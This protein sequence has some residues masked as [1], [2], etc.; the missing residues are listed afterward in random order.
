MPSASPSNVHHLHVISRQ[1]AECRG[2]DAAFAS[3]ARG[4]GIIDH[5]DATQVRIWDLA[6]TLVRQGKAVSRQQVLHV[7]SAADYMTYAD[8]VRLDG[9]PLEAEEFKAS[10]E[11]HTGGA[12]N[13]V[14][15]YMGY[16][17]LGF[18]NRGGTLDVDGMLFANRCTWA[19]I[20]EAC[21]RGTG[22]PAGSYLDGDEVA[23]VAGRGNPTVLR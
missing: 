23:A 6:D 10:P 1:A 18:L 5:N 2:F 15:A 19:H 12:L 8:R 4:Y 9:T 20:V 13:M 7:L 21:A 17:A 11:G 22:T 14:P 16:L 3:W